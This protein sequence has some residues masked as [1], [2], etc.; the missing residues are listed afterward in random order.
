M[1]KYGVDNFLLKFEDFSDKLLERR[2]KK[3][4]S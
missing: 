4:K 2:V 3:K 1:K